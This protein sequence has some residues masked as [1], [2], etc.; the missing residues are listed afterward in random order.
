MSLALSWGRHLRVLPMKLF[1]FFLRVLHTL[2]GLSCIFVIRAAFPF[3]KIPE[4]LHWFVPSVNLSRIRNDL[5]F[6][7]PFYFPF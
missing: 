5:A 7:N 6:H 2:V 3:H 4:L 1:H